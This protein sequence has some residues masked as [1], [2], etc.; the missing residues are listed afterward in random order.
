MSSRSLD[1]LGY[2]VPNTILS[3]IF[4]KLLLLD[5]VCRLDTAMCD[6]NRRRLFLE[7]VGSESCVWQ[8][9]ENRYFSS[10]MISWL[11]T[12][13]IK[14]RH[15]KC[16]CNRNKTDAAMKVG[17]CWSYLQWLSIK[18]HIVDDGV[19]EIAASC[20][21]LQSI[22]LIG[23]SITDRSIIRL[24]ECCPHLHSLNLSFCDGITDTSIIRVA[25]R[26]PNL[27]KLTLATC[28]KITDKSIIKVA[29][30]CPSLY[31]LSLQQCFLVTDM[32][33][34]RVAEGCPNLRHLNLA[35]CMRISDTSIV[36]LAEGCANLSNLN[37]CF[38]CGS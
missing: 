13:S 19:I 23:C 38:V 11:Y 32:G 28:R 18:G 20:P 33:I 9:D 7:C 3:E 14:I 37:T 21:N 17:R 16:K 29:E 24:S 30:H 25:E 8:G 34:I 6:K 2:F 4:T 12:R 10:A 15:L 35:N 1:I 5:D 27:N 22:E 36:R 26:I 31:S